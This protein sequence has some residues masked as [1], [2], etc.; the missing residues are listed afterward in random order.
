M[1]LACVLFCCYFCPHF[2][3][4]LKSTEIIKVV[5]SSYFIHCYLRS[6]KKK[7]KEKQAMQF[8]FVFW[9]EIIKGI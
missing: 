8:G 9:E 3:H 1:K 7:K 5:G 2:L 4:V 6:K